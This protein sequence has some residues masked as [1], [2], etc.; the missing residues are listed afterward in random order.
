M[1]SECSDILNICLMRSRYVYIE[2]K[3]MD[4]YLI[5]FCM[6]NQDSDWHEIGQDHASSW[7][8]RITS[9]RILQIPFN[10]QDGDPINTIPL[11]TTSS[12][13]AAIHKTWKESIRL[14]AFI[15]VLT[16]SYHLKSDNIDCSSRCFCSYQQGFSV[17]LGRETFDIHNDKKEY[18]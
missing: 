14:I 16:V 10:N 7:D 3:G 5:F 8:N 1:F 6:K 15:D 18:F 12:P 9:K 4:K 13:I 11:W 2:F 17:V